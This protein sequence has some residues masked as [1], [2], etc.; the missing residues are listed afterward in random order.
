MAEGRII[1]HPMMSDDEI[2]LLTR[3]YNRSRVIL[4]FGC[5]GSTEIAAASSASKIYCVESDGQWIT[6]CS[7]TP[8]IKARLEDSSL[9]FFHA[10]VG[11]TVSYGR[12]ANKDGLAQWPAYS[13][14]VW[15]MI[16]SDI[17]D[18]ILIDGRFRMSCLLQ[19]L[20]RCT[21]V[22]ILMH[23]F[24]SRPPYQEALQ[25]TDVVE[26]IADLVVL[27]P[28]SDVSLRHLAIRSVEYLLDPD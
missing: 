21:D 9:K 10:F 22:R 11:E 13:C 19:S 8:K 5:G 6:E 14:G 3:H 7:Q 17:P 27:M 1:M 26:S 20:L 2:G 15:S 25:Y 24:W 18:V 16:N 28:K 4:E 12:P 23:D